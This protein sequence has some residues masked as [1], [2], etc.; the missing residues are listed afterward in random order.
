[1]G[2]GSGKV[3]FAMAWFR[4]GLGFS[5]VG[6]GLVRMCMVWDWGLVLSALAGYGGAWYGIG[7]WLGSVRYGRVWD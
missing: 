4:M 3:V 5:P 2:L 7:V 6:L 1:M